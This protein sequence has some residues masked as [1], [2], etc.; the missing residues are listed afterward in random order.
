MGLR[1]ESALTVAVKTEVI[2]MVNESLADPI[3]QYSDETLMSIDLLLCSEIVTANEW[4]LD[5]H[6]NG[7]TKILIHKG[8]LDK[9]GIHGEL[10]VA[11]YM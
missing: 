6:E 4:I 5:I 10:A 2:E 1:G 11:V 9:L 8:G 3:T 7:I